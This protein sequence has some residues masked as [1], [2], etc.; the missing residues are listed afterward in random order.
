MKK[1]FVFLVLT[2]L[3]VR[4]VMAEPEVVICVH[5]ILGSSASMAYAACSLRKAGYHVEN[6]VY[7]SRDK[8]ILEHSED[9]VLEIKWVAENYKGWRIH[10]VTHSMGGL[11]LRAALNHPECPEI[12]K[13]GRAVLYAPPNKGSKFGRK[14][15]VYQFVCKVLG[16][17]SGKELLV[18]DEDGFDRLGMF[19]KTLEVLVIAGTKNFNPMIDEM[20]DGVLCV[21]ETALKTPFKWKAFRSDHLMMPWSPQVLRATVQF[22]KDGS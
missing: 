19:P 18:T 17:K 10:F 6:W 7:P 8:T 9:L 5:G 16:L 22:L 4:S 13:S 20:S 21:E 12:A 3:P 1:L 11:I 2:V 15:R 14:M